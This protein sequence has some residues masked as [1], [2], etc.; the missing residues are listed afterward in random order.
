MLISLLLA[1]I[2]NVGLW[3]VIAI[4]PAV[5]A[6]FGIDRAAVSLLFSMTMIGFAAGNFLLGWLVDKRGVMHV[7][8]FSGIVVSGSYALSAYATSVVSLAAL[9]LLI[10]FGG[11]ASFGPL[12]ADISQWFL[13]RRGL[14]VAIVASGN[15]LSG[16]IWPMAL[17]GVLENDGWRQVHLWLAVIAALVMVPLAFGLRRR[18]PEAAS[19]AAAALAQDA[20]ARTSLSPRA[21]QW[22]LALA[23]VGCCVAMSMPQVHLV[24]LCVD[25]GF[26]TA[27][28]TQML[29]LMLLGGVVSRLCS[30]LLVDWMGAVKTVLLGSILQCLA[31]ALYLPSSTLPSLFIVSMIFGLSQGGIV[32]GYA[33]IIREYLPPK[34][35]GARVGLVMMATIFGMAFGGYVSGEIFDLTGSYQAAFLHGI[36][37]NILNILLLLFVLWRAMGPVRRQ[38]PA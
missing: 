24:A 14:A 28:G 11:G 33:L 20:A 4:M 9:Q 12:L 15:Y 7:I 30:G 38:A 10:G 27:V 1:T 5:Q 6:E 21:L 17:S 36:L 18:L 8:L 2:G 31:L 22:I 25:Y 3:S 13:R 26:G 35:A 37:W 19:Q 32:P 34:E 23:G 29:S 16:A